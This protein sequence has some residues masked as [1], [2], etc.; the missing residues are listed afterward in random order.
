MKKLLEANE[1]TVYE[2]N[3]EDVVAVRIAI[4]NAF[5]HSIENLK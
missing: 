5:D 4:G 1:Y 2:N 3:E